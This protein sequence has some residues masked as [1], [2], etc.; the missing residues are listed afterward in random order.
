MEKHYKALIKSF[1]IF[2]PIF[3]FTMIYSSS[4]FGNIVIDGNIND[5][6]WNDAQKFEFSSKDTKLNVVA[7]VKWD[8]KFFYFACKIADTNVQGKYKEGIQ[9][10]WED[11]DVEYYLETDNKKHNGR[12]VNSYQLLF[13]AAGAYNDTV[14]DGNTYDFK[15][16]SHVEYIVEL[17]QGTT[18]NNGN[19]NDTGWHLESRLPWKD[20]NVDGNKVKGKTMGWNI[21]VATQPEAVQINSSPKVIGWTNNHDC[22][23]WGEITFDKGY[24]SVESKGKLYDTWG[25]IK[26]CGK[27]K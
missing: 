8:E 15:W 1:F 23:N 24:V 4:L 2:M 7:L 16:D 6:E 10:V 9:N 5:D 22:S 18:I 27:L 13:D 14:G 19:D 20:I 12:S 3:L 11:D 17:D 25:T 26:L 21:L